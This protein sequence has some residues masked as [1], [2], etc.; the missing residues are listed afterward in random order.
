VLFDD[1]TSVSGKLDAKGHARIENVPAIGAGVSYGEDEREAVPRK[2]HKANAVFGAKARTE[3]EAQSLIEQYL[4]QEAEHYKS[5]FFPDEIEDMTKA[6]DGDG[7]VDLAYDF[8]VNDYLYEDE[9]SA[10][11]IGA[12]RA[13]REI[14]GQD[15]RGKT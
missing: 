3:E 15:E 7:S 2:Q 13:Y 6:T 8:H 4:A 5:N 9:E 1:G 11:A 14:H 12:E 10:E